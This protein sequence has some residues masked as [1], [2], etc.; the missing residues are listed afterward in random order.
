[1]Y[2][3]SDIYLLAFWNHLPSQ[4]SEVLPLP[5]PPL[6]LSC[7]SLYNWKSPFPPVHAFNGSLR[8][9]DVESTGD[10]YVGCIEHHE[11]SRKSQVARE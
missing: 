4:S 2:P 6:F 8:L 9:V 11:G 1:M 10:D 3:F 7:A 5:I